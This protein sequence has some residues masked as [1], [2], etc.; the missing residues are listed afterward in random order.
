MKFRDVDQGDGPVGECACHRHDELCGEGALSPIVLHLRVCGHMHTALP[1]PRKKP[2]KSVY[3]QGTRCLGVN[4]QTGGK[5]N[6]L[7]T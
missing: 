6:T 4:N 7:E 5:S 1:H 3:H 2:D